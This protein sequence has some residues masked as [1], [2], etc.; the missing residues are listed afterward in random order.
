MK[1]LILIFTSILMAGCN[2]NKVVT[3]KLDNSALAQLNVGKKHFE[4]HCASCHDLKNPK[5]FTPEEWGKI[6]PEMV[7]Y[8]NQDKIALNE[9]AQ[10]SILNYLVTLS[11]K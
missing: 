10:E 1:N 5:S 2:S 8:V 3:I 6:V 11:K 4:V 7:L 9:K